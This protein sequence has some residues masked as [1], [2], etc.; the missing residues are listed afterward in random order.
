MYLVP[1]GRWLLTVQR[2]RQRGGRP[3]SHLEV[4]SL[5]NEPY[6]IAC[7]DVAGFYRTATMEL[8]EGS[9][10][11]TLAVAY[12]TDDTEAVAVYSVPFRDRSEFLFYTAPTLTPTTTIRLPPHPTVKWQSAKFIHQLSLSDGQLV[13]SVVDPM[14]QTG[15]SLLQV[16]LVDIKSRVSQWLDPKQLRRFSDV[17]VKVYA[18]NGYF[19]L[20][21]PARQSIILRVYAMPARLCTKLATDPASP[22]LDLGP[23]ICEYEQPLRHDSQF[24]DIISVSAPSATSISA[25][26]ICSFHD[27]SPRVG[28]VTRF[29]LPA[30]GPGPHLPG[31]TRYFSMPSH[32]SAQLAP[33]R[34]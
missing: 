11:I 2:P 10:S 3:G 7:V 29:P 32:V 33:S 12:E 27:T 26:V 28:Q 15:S 6:A 20:L 4:W 14:G 19:L 25:L 8:K 24:Q 31:A 18:Y 9:Q 21:G 5:E 30:A 34:P 23:A 1:G 17:W 16:F 22:F 13:V